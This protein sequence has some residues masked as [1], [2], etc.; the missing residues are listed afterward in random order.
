MI[1]SLPLPERFAWYL[2]K[3]SSFQLISHHFW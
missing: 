2:S 3:A 1:V